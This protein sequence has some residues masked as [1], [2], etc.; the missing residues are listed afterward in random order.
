MYHRKLIG[1]QWRRQRIMAHHGIETCIS[2]SWV[3]AWRNINNV[4][5]MTQQL[6]ISSSMAAYINNVAKASKQM[7]AYR[8]KRP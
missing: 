2:V 3:A 1:N 8:K 5:R 6:S 4:Y 7:A